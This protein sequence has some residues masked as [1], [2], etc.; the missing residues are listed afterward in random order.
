MKSKI[1]RIFITRDMP[2]KPSKVLI[3][4]NHNYFQLKTLYYSSKT[5]QS[6]FGF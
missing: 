3:K 4:I 2:Q 6:I 1:K 5:N